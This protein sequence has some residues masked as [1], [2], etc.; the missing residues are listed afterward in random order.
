LEIVKN[1]DADPAY[2]RKVADVAEMTPIFEMIAP[3]PPATLNV[4]AEVQFVPIPVTVTI[5]ADPI[6]TLIN[7]SDDDNKHFT[8]DVVESVELPILSV[9]LA[10]PVFRVNVADVED[11]TVRPL[12]DAPDPP[13]TENVVVPGIHDVPVPVAVIDTD[14]LALTEFRLRVNPIAP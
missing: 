11:E 13:V 2:I 5:V 8:Y 7:D 9:P 4:V 1:P 3:V 14:E 12:I 10:V 6:G